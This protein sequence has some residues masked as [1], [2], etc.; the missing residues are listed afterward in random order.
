MVSIRAESRGTTASKE[1]VGMQTR[2]R[3]QCGAHRRLICF[4]IALEDGLRILP[5]SKVAEV[6][7]GGV[8]FNSVANWRRKLCQPR[9]GMCASSAIFSIRTHQSRKR[10]CDG[11]L[12]CPGDANIHASPTNGLSRRAVSS[13]P[14]ASRVRGVSCSKPILSFSPRQV[15]RL[16]SAASDAALVGCYPPRRAD[17]FSGAA[18][19]YLPAFG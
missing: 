13:A 19:C 16:F 12:V 2:S 1:P 17:A 14:T 15:S 8:C 11:S 4:L 7:K 9:P 18:E 5:A 3:F 10:C 6:A